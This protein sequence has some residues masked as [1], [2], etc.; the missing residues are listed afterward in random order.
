MTLVD[1]HD[2][3]YFYQMLIADKLAR[4]H[5]LKNVA[6][7]FFQKGD[8]KKAAKIYQKINGYY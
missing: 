4:I 3:G 6:G 8:Y 2:T 5:H 1:I 7:Q